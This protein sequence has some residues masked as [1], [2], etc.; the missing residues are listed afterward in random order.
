M[1]DLPVE[2]GITEYIK[3]KAPEKYHADLIPQF[4]AAVFLTSYL[5]EMLS[6]A[7]T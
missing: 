2:K 1:R 5:F 4:R 6:S 3:R 7:R